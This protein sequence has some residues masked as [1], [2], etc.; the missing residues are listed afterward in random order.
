MSNTDQ[1]TSPKSVFLIQALKYF[2]NFLKT[3]PIIKLMFNNLKLPLNYLHVTRI[4]LFEF[5]G[6]SNKNKNLINHNLILNT[7]DR[8]KSY[9]YIIILKLRILYRIF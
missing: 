7:L 6:N 9:I 1:N 5:K 8:K 3:A 4:L 2:C